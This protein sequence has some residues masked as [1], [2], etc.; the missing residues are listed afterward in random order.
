MPQDKNF[1]DLA[2]ELGKQLAKLHEEVYETASQVE[3]QLESMWT[4]RHA[5]L[6]P[7]LQAWKESIGATSFLT[8]ARRKSNYVFEPSLSEPHPLRV[9]E[10]ELPIAD[11]TGAFD[12]DDVALAASLARG[13]A[14]MQFCFAEKAAVVP[15][16]LF[17]NVIGS[18]IVHFDELD[19]DAYP[20]IVRE[21]SE[22][23]EGL[24]RIILGKRR[25]RRNR[26]AQAS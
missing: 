18:I 19:P 11:A 2:D 1:K 14:E 9:P 8:F 4:R 12:G 21:T 17:Q 13:A 5:D 15:F 25:L 26:M 24:R 22:C 16:I 10:E 7:R 20:H 6:L 23:L 3:T